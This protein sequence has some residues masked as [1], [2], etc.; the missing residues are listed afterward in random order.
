[1]QISKDV[2]S[3]GYLPTHT[4]ELFYITEVLKNNSQVVGYRLQDIDN[5]KIE[6]WFYEKEL[7]AVNPEKTAFAIE[8]IIDQ[9]ETKNGVE[10]L[11]KWKSYDSK[12]NSWVKDENFVN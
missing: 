5:E 12:W 2:F 1:M 9:R 10:F 3:K 8:K 7:V 4:E 11:V 6:G